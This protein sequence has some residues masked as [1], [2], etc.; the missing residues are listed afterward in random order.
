MKGSSV[1]VI[2]FVLSLIATAALLF[3]GFTFGILPEI[4]VAAV[5]LVIVKLLL[6]RTA[7]GILASGKYNVNAEADREHIMIITEPEDVGNLSFGP[8]VVLHVSHNTPL[9][10]GTNFARAFGPYLTIREAVAEIEEK[11]AE[12]GDKCYKVVLPIHL[13]GALLKLEDPDQIDEVMRVAG[14]TKVNEP[15]TSAGKGL[16]N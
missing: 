1:E 10:S 3:I 4:A 15:S 8:V 2:K 5:M 16:V 14:F 6:V 9:Q 11:Q 12:S 13:G 7:K